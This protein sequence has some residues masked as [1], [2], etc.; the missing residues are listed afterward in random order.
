[1]SGLD[2]GWGKQV[3]HHDD[4]KVGHTIS[5]TVIAIYCEAVQTFIFS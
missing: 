2:R 1:M 3:S 4:S 5:I